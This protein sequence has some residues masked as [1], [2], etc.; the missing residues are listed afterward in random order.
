MD[1]AR[2]RTPETREQDERG[3]PLKASSAPDRGGVVGFLRR[4]LNRAPGSYRALGTLLA[5]G[6]IWLF[7]S[8]KSEY[9]L[10]SE[11]IFNIFLQC[12][13]RRRSSPLG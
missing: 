2:E 12:V 1:E 13:E 9:F 7:F 5:F 3:K 11:N 4:G 10:T 6:L 8:L